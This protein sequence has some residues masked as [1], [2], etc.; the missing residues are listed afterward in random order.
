MGGQGDR[1]RANACSGERGSSASART[2]RSAEG[3]GDEEAG[4]EESNEAERL[5]ASKNGGGRY[6]SGRGA[7]DAEAH[8]RRLSAALGSARTRSSRGDR[9]AILALLLPHWP[10]VRWRGLAPPRG[11]AAPVAPSQFFDRPPV[12]LGTP[13]AYNRATG[14]QTII[15]EA[16]HTDFGAD[17]HRA[18]QGRGAA[19]RCGRERGRRRRPERR[20]VT[21]AC[22]RLC[23]GEAVGGGCC[24]QLGAV[25][26]GVECAHGARK[27]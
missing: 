26:Q 9:P 13:R 16:L 6:G 24:R 15:T 5:A 23:A 10:C 11:A 3:Q 14:V 8:A 20:V 7:D 2:G 25:D 27:H 12:H 19:G 21:R 22:A 17:S 1:Q 18:G 4:G